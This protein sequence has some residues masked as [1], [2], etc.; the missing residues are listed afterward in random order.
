MVSLKQHQLRYGEGIPELKRN[1]KKVSTRKN[2]ATVRRSGSESARGPC[3]QLKKYL[4]GRTPGENGRHVGN[5]RGKV[6]GLKIF[7][8]EG[9]K[10]KE[11]NTRA[12]GKIVARI[13]SQGG[14]G[15]IK[16]RA[17]TKSNRH[18]FL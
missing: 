3:Y 6:Q 8:E 15:T 1:F 17:F 7:R 9:G 12:A 5:C 18:S 11:D 16:K 13:G 14:S 4:T 10:S 2:P